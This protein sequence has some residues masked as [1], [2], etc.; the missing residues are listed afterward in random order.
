M[1]ILKVTVISGFEMYC[2]ETLEC[3]AVEGTGET[4][5]RCAGVHTAPLGT[6]CVNV[7]TTGKKYF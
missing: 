7:H 5:Q 6:C 2:E 3:R 4:T 1:S